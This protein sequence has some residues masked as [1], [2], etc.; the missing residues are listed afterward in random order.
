MIRFDQLALMRGSRL[1]FEQ[2]SMSIHPGARVGLVG[3]NGS[4]KSSLFALI[5][6]QLQAEAGDLFLPENWV[7]AHVAQETP[8]DPRPAQDYVLD[9]DA[10]WAA[11]DRS[12][13][14]AEAHE[15]GE[16]LLRLHERMD[17]I[18]G[19]TAR[20]R[21]ARLMHGLGFSKGDEDRPVSGFSGG[22]RMR[23]NLA[24]ALMCR[25]DLLLLDEPTNHLDLEAVLWLEDWLKRYAGTLIL[26]SHDRD[27]LDAIVGQILHLDHQRLD[28]YT[29]NYSGFEHQRAERLMQQQAVYEKQVEERQRLQKF[30]DRF[31]AKATKARQA[32]SRIKALER[33]E[34]VAP[35]Y[36]E[37]V[38]HFEFPQP[39]KLP[40]SLLHLQDVAIG[41]D[42]T[43]ILR[44]LN[45]DIQSGD[46]I[47]LLGPNGAGKSTLVRLL[48]GEI[49]AL[50]GD[51][52]IHQDLKIGYFAQ[53]HSEAL[54]LNSSALELL[55]KQDPGLSEQEGRDFLGR[56]GFS[57]DE[58]LKPVAQYSGG[59][60]A[61]LNLALIV[62][63]RP[64]LLLLDEPTNHLDLEMRHALTV[65]LQGYEGAVLLVSHDR[66]LLRT[67]SERFWLVSDATIHLFEGGLDQYA[68]W[69][70]DRQANAADESESVPEQGAESRKERKRR[71][72]EHRQQTRPLRDEIKKAD[73]AMEKIRGRLA[74]IEQ[75]L[76]RSEMYEEPARQALQALLKE[77]GELR[78]RMDELE[79]TWM[80][81]SE[82]L[83][84][85]QEPI[86]S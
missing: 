52:E 65:A 38:F 84:A 28:L 82:K 12:I 77:Q 6:G 8:A 7:I 11:L 81:A 31:R 45:L 47:A 69:L 48:A 33:M 75:E 60:K 64:N 68:Q 86:T 78:G 4:G 15:Q 66:H 22:W 67:V 19:Y 2:A 62:Y 56:F 42:Q 76:S 34:E 57:G 16:E 17:R 40:H 21:A 27:F 55:L 80:L 23:L 59:E 26:I 35:A 25:S 74:D 30:I 49:Q 73:E 13:L 51:L 53:H 3:A 9:G 20:S 72:A 70:A 24:Q 58:A 37:S 41:Y 1:L 61:R 44:D 54:D 14:E 10:E 71:E 85:L 5:R 32:Q 79:E 18:D 46:R 36:A 50:S 83:E 63:S 29:G 39:E 43:P